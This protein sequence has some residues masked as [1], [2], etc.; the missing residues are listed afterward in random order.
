MNDVL[1]RPRTIES[2]KRLAKHIKAAQGIKHLE[3]LKRA[4]QQAGYENFDHARAAMPQRPIA[5]RSPSASTAQT[6]RIYLTGYWLSTG[7]SSVKRETLLVDLPRSMDELG[8]RSE[9]R[10]SRRLA[11]F[12]LQA[13]DHLVYRDL[14]RN[15]EHTQEQ[16]SV[17]ARVLQFMAATGLKEARRGTRAYPR[18]R[19]GGLIS[20]PGQDH[21]RVWED[22]S[23]GQLLITDEP[24]DAKSDTFNEKRAEWAE[25]YGYVMVR[26]AWPGMHNP[27]GGCSLFLIAKDQQLVSQIEQ[28]A[29][30]IPVMPSAWAG[31]SA[32]GWPAYRSPREIAARPDGR[33]YMPPNPF[34]PKP[35]PHG[36][37]AFVQTF[38]GPQLRPDA[39]MPIAAHDEAAGLLDGLL[40][41][42][43]ERRGIYNRIDTVRSTLDEWIQREYDYSELSNET[44]HALYYRNG[45]REWR[46]SITAAESK[47]LTRKLTRLRALLMEHYPD[48]KPLRGL[49]RKLDLAGTSLDNWRR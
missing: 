47:D 23:T 27:H 7:S 39:R 13:N 6:N 18:M 46:K 31:E 45:S 1:I 16:L 11:N 42:T 38:A 49:L 22:A 20:V 9:L 44:F 48:C 17:A 14:A 41:I 24:Y 5:P 30:A 2:V 15:Q 40:S 21:A 25:T 37:K 36:T 34:A 19:H 10:R 32:D 8:G 26:S 33:G 43:H 29:Q 12:K 3:A 35:V 28:L 4:A